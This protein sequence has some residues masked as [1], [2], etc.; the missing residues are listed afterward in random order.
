MDQMGH[1]YI[2]IAIEWCIYWFKFVWE[3]KIIPNFSTECNIGPEIEPTLAMYCEIA[4]F[5][6]ILGSEM[7]ALVEIIIFLETKGLFSAYTFNSQLKD[8]KMSLYN[9]K[10]S[11]NLR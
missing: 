4:T 5:G 8:P 9:P 7:A 6:S 2:T 10:L 1:L 3:H 11:C